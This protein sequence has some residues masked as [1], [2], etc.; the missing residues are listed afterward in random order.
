MQKLL[1]PVVI[2]LM[3]DALEWYSLAAAKGYTPAEEKLRARSSPD[4]HAKWIAVQRQLPRPREP[5]MP[6]L[7][8]DPVSSTDKS[9]H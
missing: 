8:T 1:A 9:E 7:R 4:H 6:E 2:L 3:E 5:G